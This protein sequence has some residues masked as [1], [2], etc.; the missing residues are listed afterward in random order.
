MQPLQNPPLCSRTRLLEEKINDY[1][2]REKSMKFT[3]SLRYI[4]PS[5]VNLLLKSLHEATHAWPWKQHMVCVFLRQCN[6]FPAYETLLP[7]LVWIFPLDRKIKIS[8]PI[9]DEVR[10]FVLAIHIFSY[11]S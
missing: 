5:L 10:I 7:S 4:S 11:I 3:F 2:V 6:S 9:K 1:S 8:Q